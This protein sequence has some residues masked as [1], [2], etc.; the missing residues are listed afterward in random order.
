MRALCATPR[1]CPCRG[2]KKTVSRAHWRSTRCASAAAKGPFKRSHSKP[3][4]GWGTDKTHC[5][6]L[7][8]VCPPA[9]PSV[10]L[11]GGFVQLQAEE[12]KPPPSEATSSSIPDSIYT[13]LQRAALII[14]SKGGSGMEGE[15]AHCLGMNQG[16]WKIKADCGEIITD[17]SCGIM[18]MHLVLPKPCLLSTRINQQRWVCFIQ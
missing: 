6:T 13:D 4:G 2:G 16:H 8:A 18:L 3:G 9:S 14:E 10:C 1:A 15:P 5:Q 7:P 11:L 17:C 12:C